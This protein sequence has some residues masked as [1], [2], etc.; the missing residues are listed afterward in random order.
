M[1]FSKPMD[2]SNLNVG[3]V[4]DRL[5]DIHPAIRPLNVKRQSTL[6]GQLIEESPGPLKDVLMFSVSLIV[7]KSTGPV[8]SFTKKEVRPNPVVISLTRM[9]LGS[10]TMSPL[11]PV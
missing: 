4:I 6:I 5:S 11:R 10:K 2:D 7:M 8:I 9:S 3:V 1:C